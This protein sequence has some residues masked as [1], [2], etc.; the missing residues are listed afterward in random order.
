[1]FV[2]LSF[3]W[4]LGLYFFVHHDKFLR[5]KRYVILTT[6]LKRR[7]VILAFDN[8]GDTFT[9]W[10]FGPALLKVL[11]APLDIPGTQKQKLFCNEWEQI[12]LTKRLKQS[13]PKLT[14]KR[15]LTS[16]AHVD[17]CL[18]SRLTWLIFSWKSSFALQEVKKTCICWLDYDSKK[19]WKECVVSFGFMPNAVI[20]HPLLCEFD[21]VVEY[22]ELNCVLCIEES[23]ASFDLCLTQ[24]PCSIVY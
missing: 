22:A 15:V 11:P 16:R 14:V 6:P 10:Q 9:L 21:H 19:I 24:L 13:V 4:T 12:P 18:A 20:L 3:L 1:M 7:I 17:L 2:F 23:V 8:N 5:R